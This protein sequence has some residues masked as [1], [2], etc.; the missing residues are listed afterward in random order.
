M[1]FGQKENSIRTYF[2][3]KSE[4]SIQKY[5][6]NLVRTSHSPLNWLITKMN[7]VQNCPMD[8]TWPIEDAPVVASGNKTRSSNWD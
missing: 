7:T 1:L 5:H 4:L 8:S 2:A 3:K 6:Q